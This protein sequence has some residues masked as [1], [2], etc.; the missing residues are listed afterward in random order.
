MC[1]GGALY[2][3]LGWLRPV[4]VK[5]RVEACTGCRD[6]IPV[7][8][9]GINPI[10]Q[11]ASIECDNC[12]VCI[13]HCGDGALYYAVGLPGVGKRSRQRRSVVQLD[14][15]KKRQRSRITAALVPFVTLLLMPRVAVAHHILGLPHYSYKE[16]Y[17][18]RPTLEYPATTG[19]YDVLFT[20]YPGVPVPGEPANLAFYIKDRESKRVYDEP[21]TIRVLR[22]ATFGDN[23]LI[24][25]STTRTPFDHEYKLHMTFPIDGEYIVELSMSV[26]GRVEVIPFLMIAG[27]PGAAGSIAAAS[28]IGLVLVLV[29]V[30]AIQKKRRRR[31]VVSL[32]QIQTG[33]K[34]VAPPRGAKITTPR[35]DAAL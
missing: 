26:E 19:P 34:R 21:L 25:P 3:L 6:C 24:L 14:T 18:Q 17:P 23:E 32:N 28:A 10:T 9:G 30:R 29:G 22:T 15:D 1:P 33:A 4:R 35:I 12:G 8:E 16:N 20:S 13:R 5:L 11:S 31:Q 2:G 27:E 7:C